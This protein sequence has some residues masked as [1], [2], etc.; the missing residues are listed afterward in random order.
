MLWRESMGEFSSSDSED[1][2][3]FY[4]RSYKRVSKS[5]RRR[6]QPRTYLGTTNI[7]EL[8]EIVQL[9]SYDRKR[10]NIQV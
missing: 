5:D 6:S 3:E 4:R 2:D 7:D 1:S 9:L 10:D 8:T